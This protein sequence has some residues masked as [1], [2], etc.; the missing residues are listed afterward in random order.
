MKMLSIVRPLVITSAFLACGL[1][2]ANL[3][4]NGSFENGTDPVVFTKLVAVNS[5]SITDWTVSAG[6]IDYIGSYWQ[7][8]EGARSIDLV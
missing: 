5:T 4:Q 8:A 1:A 6:T 7:A 3:I 2:Q